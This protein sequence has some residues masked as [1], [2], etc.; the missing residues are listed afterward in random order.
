M[1]AFL[2]SITENSDVFK[3]PFLALTLSSPT[4][5]VARNSVL[6]IYMEKLD[7]SF[8]DPF[9][10]C[11]LMPEMK[12]NIWK[13]RESNPDPLLLKQPLKPLDHNSQSQKLGCCQLSPNSDLGE[14]ERKEIEDY[15]SS[16]S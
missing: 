1:L 9:C 13:G 7:I 14:N 5:G 2:A 4:D 10:V 16:G 11:I 3:L 8:L 6:G 15:N 12:K